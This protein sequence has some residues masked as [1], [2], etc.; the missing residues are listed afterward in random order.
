MH[1]GTRAAR[2]RARSAGAA[3]A[4]ASLVSWCVACSDDGATPVGK[5]G[6]SARFTPNAGD[7]A[8]AV[9]VDGQGGKDA[10]AA[11]DSAAPD[12]A[13]DGA[14]VDA[15]Q[16]EASDGARAGPADVG[17]EAG[18]DAPAVGSFGSP[19]QSADDC[20]GGQC[21]EHQDGKV[22][23]KL[24]QGACPAG[25]SCVGLGAGGS[26]LTFVC[27][28]TFARLCHPCASHGDC[29]PAGVSGGVCLPT[30][31]NGND[32]SFCAMKCQGAGSCPS[33]YACKPA[34][35]GSACQPASGACSCN[36]NAVAQQLATSC[37]VENAIGVCL[38]SVVCTSPTPSACSA[39]SPTAEVCDG[40][41][42]DCNGK[43]DDIATSACEQSNAS[44]TCKGKVVGC[45]VGGPKCDAKVPAPETCNLTDDDCDGQTDEGL[46]EDGNPC[47]SGSC[48]GDGSCQQQPASGACDDGNVCTGADACA[49]GQCKGSA[50]KACNDNNP[51]T[52]DLCDA[53]KGCIAKP[54]DPGT[55]CADDGNPCTLDQCASGVCAH[56]AAPGTVA[57]ADDGNPCTVDQCAAGQCAHPAAAAGA[58]C[59]DDNLVCTDDVCSGVG[60]CSHPPSKVGTAC[61]DD[62]DACTGDE[63]DG[64]GVCAHPVGKGMCKIGGVCVAAGGKN[65]ANPCQACDPSVTQAAFVNKDGLACSDDN[66]CTTGDTCSGGACKGSAKSCSSLD[67]ACAVGQCGALGACAAVPKPSGTS[68]SDG[69]PCTAVDVCNGAGSCAGKPV[70]CSALSDGCNTG[71]C[72]NG[73]CIKQQKPANTGCSDNNA[74]TTND[75]C[76]AGVCIGK[77]I[78][79]TGKTDACNTGACS[80]GACVAQP[81][82]NNTVCDDG[83]PCTVSDKCSAGKCAGSSTADVNE[84]NNSSPGKAITDKSDCDALAQLTATI[85]PIG[86]VDWY[87]FTAKD[88]SFCT[89]KPSAKIDNL[90]ADYDLCIYFQCGNG[91]TGSD[92][93]SCASGSKVSGGPSG[94]YGCCSSAAGTV[95][96]FV[97]VN[98][99]CTFLGTGSDGGKVWIK[100]TAKP[101]ATCGGYSLTWGAKS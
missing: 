63:C 10:A 58:P 56:T 42:N 72:A 35:G 39:A 22:C 1:L 54:A 8:S 45:G 52:A 95:S 11:G 9:K 51:C 97:K 5:A 61:P 40:A 89:I 7:V 74:C 43:T 79:C 62:G 59:P 83:S 57:C 53:T 92:T 67:S 100:V 85:S 65:P 25:W 101:A 17:A 60:S 28:P 23:G 4:W 36:A 6:G 82:A 38:G 86:D 15:G 80:N 91:T 94:S 71:L 24:C 2:T 75:V 29:N 81:K 18:A 77:G 20:D 93:V 84:P 44:G 99:S 87:S 33:G 78:D 49:N 3:V 34:L 12:L 41:D 21:V 68:C 98:P 90:G 32:G 69:N 66:A 76:T 47:T 64:A 37:A 27:V 55:A 70:D 88:E 31:A 16:A 26:D 46:C 73:A 19:C 96:E 48:N 13:V 14:R 50:D 30:G